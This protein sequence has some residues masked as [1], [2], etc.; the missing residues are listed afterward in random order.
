MEDYVALNIKNVE[1]EALAAEVAG[2]TGETKTEAI[3]QALLERRRRLNLRQVPRGYR[4]QRLQDFLAR[5][6]W[7]RVPE[8]QVG[9]APDRQERERILGYGEDGV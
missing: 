4:R 7:T 9:K 5:E 8:D 1:V 2:L 3:R 6:I